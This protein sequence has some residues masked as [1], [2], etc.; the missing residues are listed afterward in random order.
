MYFGKEA[1]KYDLSRYIVKIFAEIVDAPN[2]SVDEIVKR[3]GYYKKM[4]QTL[5][6]SAACPARIFRTW[7]KP[8]GH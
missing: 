7:K 1:H 4:A 3:A 8:S 5:S 2:V 6:T